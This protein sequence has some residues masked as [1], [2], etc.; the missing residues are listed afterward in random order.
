MYEKQ[1]YIQFKSLFVENVKNSTKT[2][3]MEEHE[4]YKS[5]RFVYNVLSFLCF[6]YE[7]R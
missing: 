1:K 6:E 3:E 4:V 7:G 5:T 2:S